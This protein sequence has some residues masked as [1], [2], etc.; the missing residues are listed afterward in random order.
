MAKAD[1]AH[2]ERNENLQPPKGET[3]R[4][5]EDPNVPQ[6]ASFRLLLVLF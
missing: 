2:Y 1:K 3:K 6:E 5:N 4:K